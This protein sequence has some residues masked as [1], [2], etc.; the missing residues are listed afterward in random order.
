MALI[1]NV[2][3]SVVRVPR[4]TVL[5]RILDGAS[6]VLVLLALPV[7]ILLIGAPLAFLAKLLIDLF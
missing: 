4:P 2:G 5:G 3:T 6:I 7:G 1:G